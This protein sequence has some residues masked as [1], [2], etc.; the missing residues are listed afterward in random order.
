MAQSDFEAG[1]SGVESGSGDTK[2]IDYVTMMTQFDAAIGVRIA[3]ANNTSP[4]N[5]K[6]QALRLRV[7]QFQNEVDASG[8]GMQV[9]RTLP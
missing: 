1:L 7:L 8:A 9:R 2:D 5:K 6:L 3:A 4:C